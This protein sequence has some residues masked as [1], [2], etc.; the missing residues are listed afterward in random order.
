[1]WRVKQARTR[2]TSLPRR[3]EQHLSIGLLCVCNCSQRRITPKNLS[4]R[5]V[6]L[7]QEKDNVWLIEFTRSSSTG[8]RIFLPPLTAR[9]F[10]CRTSFYGDLVFPRRSISYTF[11]DF[12]AI[13]RS[14][15]Y[16]EKLTTI[17]IRYIYLEHSSTVG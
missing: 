7:P 2:T 6:D 16:D 5:C 17:I 14:L 1:M 13:S 9:E 11:R 15:Y 10:H 4:T 12:G 8:T 3:Q